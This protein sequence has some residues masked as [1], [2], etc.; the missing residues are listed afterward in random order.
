[1]IH[2]RGGDKMYKCDLCGNDNVKLWRPI[3]G[4]SP[5]ICAECAEELQIQREYDE[6]EVQKDDVIFTIRPTGKKK[7]L[8]EWHIDKNG[9]IHTIYGVGIGEVEEKT[10]EL[11]VKLKENTKIVPALP[12]PKKEKEFFEKE[13]APKK[14]RKWWKNLPTR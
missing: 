8:P 12:N 2:Q 9:E 3:N 7:I 5:L 10:D 11:E 6:F 14:I 13:E 4:N 1:M